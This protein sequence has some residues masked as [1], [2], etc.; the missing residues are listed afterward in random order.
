MVEPM[1]TLG[2]T[3][4]GWSRVVSELRCMKKWGA[5]SIKRDILHYRGAWASFKNNVNQGGGLKLNVSWKDVSQ[6]NLKYTRI[7]AG[8]IF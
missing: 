7:D 5:I 2:M 3:Q 8:L 4:K 1:R 6:T